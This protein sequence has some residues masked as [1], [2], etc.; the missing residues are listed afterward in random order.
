MNKLLTDPEFLSFCEDA[1]PIEVVEKFTDNNIRGLENIAL[2]SISTRNK[3]PSNVVNL[4]VAYF[5]SHYGNQVYNRNDL[6]RLYDYWA[7]KDVRT[8]T[9][10]AEMTN[11]DIEEV[12]KTLK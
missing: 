2:R 3:L 7:S 4:L 6:A 8:M 10:A 9:Q 12:L 11:E 5:Y 1:M